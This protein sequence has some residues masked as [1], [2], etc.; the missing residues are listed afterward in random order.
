LSRKKYIMGLIF[1]ETVERMIRVAG[2]KNVSELAREL[3]IT[4]QALSNFKKKGEIP[5]DLVI[6]FALKFKVSVDSLLSGEAS[7][8]STDHVCEAPATYGDEDEAAIIQWLRENPKDKKL[9]LKLIQ[10][11]KI[12]REALEGFGGPEILNEGGTG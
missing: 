9:I 3:D 5:A 1:S 10:G 12:T 6:K 11:R 2:L 4:P 8:A 7:P